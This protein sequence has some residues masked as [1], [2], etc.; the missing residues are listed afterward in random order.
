MDPLSIVKAACGSLPFLKFPL[1]LVDNPPSAFPPFDPRDGNFSVASMI[2][3][4]YLS[5]LS[6][7]DDCERICKEAIDYG[8][9]SGK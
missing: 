8:F 5:A 7:Q 1:A 4:T 2:D 9:C 6:T 3:H